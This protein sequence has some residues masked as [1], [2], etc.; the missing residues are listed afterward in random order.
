MFVQNVDQGTLEL[1]D[2]TQ[3][4]LVDHVNAFRI[5]DNKV[6]IFFKG[7]IEIYP[8]HQIKNIYWAGGEVK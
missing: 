2:D 7:S 3:V 1:V 6:V 4:N 5:D 8:M